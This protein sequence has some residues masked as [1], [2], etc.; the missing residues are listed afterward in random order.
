MPAG[1]K[2]FLLSHK[3]LADGIQFCETYLMIMWRKMLILLK[4][5]AWVPVYG[6]MD[7]VEERNKLALW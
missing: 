1:T 6:I 3:F 2:F 5:V 7:D 4:T